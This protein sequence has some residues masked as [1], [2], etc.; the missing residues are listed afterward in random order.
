MIPIRFPFV[1]RHVRSVRAQA[2]LEYLLLL[3]V[4]V[5]MLALF[6]PL[7]SELKIQYLHSMEKKNVEHFLSRISHAQDVL[8]VLG[9][10]SQLM[11]E[12]KPFQEWNIYSE[13]EN[14]VIEF[15]YAENLP[16]ERVQ[17]TMPFLHIL[18]MACSDSCKLIITKHKEYYLLSFESNTA[19]E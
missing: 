10:G 15:T 18:P 19:P 11:L 14:A 3:T 16:A 2:S 9:N 13:N 8:S 4:A 12:A 5:S 6:L 17:L 1:R 7:L